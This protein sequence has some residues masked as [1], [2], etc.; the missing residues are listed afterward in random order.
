MDTPLGKMIA[1]LDEGVLCRLDFADANSDGRKTE[2]A[3]SI[4]QELKDYFLGLRKQF[5]TPIKMRGTP[6]QIEVWKELQKIPFG[7]TCSY[8]DIAEA[9]QRPAAVRA[10]ANA[11]GAN[12]LSILIPCHRVLRKGGALG[13]YA[14]GLHRKK[15]LLNHEKKW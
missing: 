8:S 5:K 2:L 4:E 1:T 11:I 12:P 15:W 13:G 6:F 10:V 9:I 3:L 14:G 7:V